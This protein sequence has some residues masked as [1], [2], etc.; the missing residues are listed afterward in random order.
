MTEE[1]YHIMYLSPTQKASLRLIVYNYVTLRIKGTLDDI[2][3]GQIERAE[4]LNQIL[5]DL[6]YYETLT[7]KMPHTAYISDGK[8]EV[9]MFAAK[10]FSLI[11]Q[12]ISAYDPN[13]TLL[14][15]SQIKTLES[16][17]DYI[18]KLADMSSKYTYTK[19]EIKGFK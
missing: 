19:N 1:K 15:Q 13:H 6:D 12:A 16:E 9:L 8:G 14:V 2:A 4:A 3:D 11:M 7:G 10:A 18:K 5:D 17:F